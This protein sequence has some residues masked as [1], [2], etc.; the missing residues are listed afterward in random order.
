MSD[1]RRRL[2]H[3][4][5]EVDVRHHRLHECGRLDIQV[6]NRLVRVDNRFRNQVLL[7][8]VLATVVQVPFTDAPIFVRGEVR[9][10]T[11]PSVWKR[12]RVSVD[13]KFDLCS[14]CRTLRRAR[15]RVRYSD[16]DTKS[17]REMGE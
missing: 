16:R 10:T 11:A 4:L 15:F 9:I 14:V 5:E 3:R 7:P 2:Y 12:F 6:A 17:A 13:A 1:N 8:H